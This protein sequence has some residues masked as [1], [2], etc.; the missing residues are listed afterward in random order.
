M[1]CTNC[2]LPGH[3]KSNCNVTIRKKTWRRR[4]TNNF[5]DGVRTRSNLASMGH[6]L[7]KLKKLER[8]KKELEKNSDICVICQEQCLQKSENQTPCGHVF[9][10]G[11]LLGWL[12]ENNTCPCCRASLYDKPDI[13]DQTDL[14]NL[15]ENIVTMHYNLTPGSEERRS[16]NA[17][18]LFVFGD[19]VARLTSEQILNED[20]DWEYASTAEVEDEDDEMPDLIDEEDN[21]INDEEKQGEETNDGEED[22]IFEEWVQELHEFRNNVQQHFYEPQALME[23]ETEFNQWTNFGNVLS[24]LGNRH[25]FMRAWNA[26]HS[27]E[28][29]IPT[30]HTPSPIQTPHTPP[31]APSRHPSNSPLD[32]SPIENFTSVE[33][34]TLDEISVALQASAQLFIRSPSVE[35]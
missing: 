7:N 13:P 2:S 12:K 23:T 21:I 33:E 8:E 27:I 1:A 30:P 20:M 29:T 19:E 26:P 31:P 32:I 3:N 28:F 15:V 34:M 6:K 11:C 35:I 17:G 10:T 4:A 5:W 18:D 25:T 16:M 24:E 14:Q 9:H 22:V